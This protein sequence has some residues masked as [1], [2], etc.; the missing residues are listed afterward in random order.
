MP[1]TGTPTLG[2]HVEHHGLRRLDGIIVPPLRALKI[3]R[4]AGERPRDHAAHAMRAVEHLLARFRTC[5]KARR[6]EPHLRARRFEKRCR[7][8]CRRSGKPVRMCSAPSSFRISVPLAGLLPSVLRPMARSNGS[9]HFAWKSVRVNG[10]GLR[11]ARYP[12]SP[13]V[14][15]SCPCRANASRPCRSTAA[16]AST[17]RQDARAARYSPGRGARDWAIASGRCRGNMPERVAAGVA[18]FRGVGQLAN[19]HAVEH[20]PNNSRRS[21]R[22]YLAPFRAAVLSAHSNSSTALTFSESA[23]RAQRALRL[24]CPRRIMS[25]LGPYAFGFPQFWCGCPPR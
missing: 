3:S 6:P 13:S 15:W 4:R 5:G 23:A 7:P 14:R 18:I 16:G 24:R 12:P 9:D 17:R 8:R 21:A 1:K 11:R 22:A 19:A 2:Q 20:D 10:K 25:G